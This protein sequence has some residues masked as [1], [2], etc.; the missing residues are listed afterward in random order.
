MLM[1]RYFAISAIMGAVTRVG[2]SMRPSKE[3]MIRFRSSFG[4]SKSPG[5]SSGNVLRARFA[6]STT[7]MSGTAT[8]PVWST[9]RVTELLMK[10]PGVK[11]RFCNVGTE[12]TRMAMPIDQRGGF[13]KSQKPSTKR[14][15]PLNI[16]TEPV[17]IGDGS[18]ENPAMNLA[19]VQLQ[20]LLQ[21]DEN[22]ARNRCL[23]DTS[24][25]DDIRLSTEGKRMMA[26]QESRRGMN[27]AS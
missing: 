21:T 4:C 11:N 5:S 15:R 23:V 25:S 19:F 27:E 2:K 20:N 17:R 24:C 12:A 18:F 10:V 13:M 8:L 7:K 9:A 3:A 1:G 14:L 6:P 16:N 22:H 26:P